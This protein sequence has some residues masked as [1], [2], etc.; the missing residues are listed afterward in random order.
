VFGNLNKTIDLVANFIET[1]KDPKATL[2]AEYF[3]IKG[4][5]RER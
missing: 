5:V 3:A 2:A 4:L 1:S